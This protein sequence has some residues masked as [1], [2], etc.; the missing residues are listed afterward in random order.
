MKDL[1]QRLGRI[2]F[3]RHVFVEIT[4]VR[5]NGITVICVH[6]EE[7]GLTGCGRTF[8]EACDD[9]EEKITE[10]LFEGKDRER[11]KLIEELIETIGGD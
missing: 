1:F 9:L 6:V 4:T 3:R 2:L 5:R 11:I 7:L 10:I 8:E